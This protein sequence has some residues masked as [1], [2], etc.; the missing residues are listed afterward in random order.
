MSELTGR[1]VQSARK[2]LGWTKARL[3]RESCVPLSL[4]PHFETGGTLE[5]FQPRQLIELAFERAGIEF[6]DGET[7]RKRAPGGPSRIRR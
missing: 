2:L 3:A 7:R 5:V 6:V 1:Q 4:V